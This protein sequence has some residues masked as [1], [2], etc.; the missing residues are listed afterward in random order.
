MTTFG[1]SHESTATSLGDKGGSAVSALVH[2]NSPARKKPKKPRQH[3]AHNMTW[4]YWM[5]GV[6]HTLW[7]ALSRSIVMGRRCFRWW[8]GVILCIPLSTY[9]RRGNDDKEG[10]GRLAR[11]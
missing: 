4:S 9:V 8:S 5:K 1:L 2:V 7:S 6:D 3:A 11:I 10:S